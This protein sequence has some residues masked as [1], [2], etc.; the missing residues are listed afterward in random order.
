MTS[1]SRAPAV[2][3][4]AEDR[5]RQRSSWSRP[6]PHRRTPRKRR[7]PQDGAGHTDAEWARSPGGVP[8]AHPPPGRQPPRIL[9]G[10]SM[11]ASLSRTEVPRD[12]ARRGECRR[13]VLP[14]DNCQRKYLGRG[15]PARPSP[16]RATR[17]DSGG[18]RSRGASSPRT[19][20]TANI[21]GRTAEASFPHEDRALRFGGRKSG[22][23][24]SPWTTATLKMW[25]RVAGASL[26][27]EGHAT[28]VGGS[29]TRGASS[30]RM[31]ATP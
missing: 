8:E 11:A 3:G 10:G 1:S 25:G 16:T 14:P 13:R 24:S 21:W 20:A 22:G 4:A 31:T 5:A 12:E 18:R 2:K 19:T 7:G 23:A 17:R 29:R 28:R 9:G 26:P 27:D 6:R 15:T 30:P